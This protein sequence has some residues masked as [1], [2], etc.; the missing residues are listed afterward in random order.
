MLLIPA[1]AGPVTGSKPYPLE[2][3]VTVTGMIS[4]ERRTTGFP[5][6][7]LAVRYALGMS[8]DPFFTVPSMSF[9]WHV[10]FYVTSKDR[11]MSAK[12]NAVAGAVEFIEA[13]D[14]DLDLVVIEYN[15]DPCAV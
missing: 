2:Y 14:T 1:Q 12:F 10:T 4:G 8:G 6:E 9:D 3:F 7:N 15:F 5:D 11:E 13:A